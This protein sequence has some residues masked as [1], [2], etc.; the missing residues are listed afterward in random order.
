MILPSRAALAGHRGEGRGDEAEKD[1]GSSTE[2][3]ALYEGP[4]TQSPALGRPRKEGA[5]EPRSTRAPGESARASSP[6]GEEPSLSDSGRE[7]SMAVLAP[8]IE[9]SGAE[10]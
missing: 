6:I 9:G 4:S 8:G 5:L 2:A 10:L 7:A 3:P 1:R